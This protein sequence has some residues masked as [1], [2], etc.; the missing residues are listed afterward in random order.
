MSIKEIADLV[1]NANRAID[2][3]G[4]GDENDIKKVYKKYVK[5]CHPDLNRDN[6]K[7]CED[8]MSL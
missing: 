6:S 2:V 7:M 8:I 5:V 3:F 1:L 4:E